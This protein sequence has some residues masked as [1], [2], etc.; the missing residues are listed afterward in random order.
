MN[1]INC[2]HEIAGNFCSHCGQKSQ[3]KR[4]S[5][6]EGWNDFWGRVYGLDGML[7][8]T[9]RDLTLRPG[10]VCL[11]Y[12]EGNRRK[13]YGPVGYFFLMIT[14]LYLLSSL[15]GVD[16]LEFLKSRSA[17]FSEG[18]QGVESQAFVKRAFEKISDNMKMLSFLMIGVQALVSRFL[19][20]RKSGFNLIE[21]AVLPFYTQGHI[22]WLT[23]F[24]LL[25]FGLGNIH[26]PSWI[27]VLVTSFYTSYAYSNFFHHQSK[28]KIFIK[29]I[30]VHFLTQ[31]FFGMLVAI[32]LFAYLAWFK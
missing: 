11:R 7:P 16:M 30:G 21:H 4:L 15:L 24:H 25:L 10:E 18:P 32:L 1:C 8:R 23:V 26:L 22:Y 27:N 3:V 5:L 20:F 2:G 9:L 17:D 29:G 6:R 13:Y 19:F 14:L 12:I 31:F 28:T